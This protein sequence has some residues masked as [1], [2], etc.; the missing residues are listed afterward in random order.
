MESGIAK[1]WSYL[2]LGILALIFGI[3]VLVWPTATVYVLIILFGVY[4][5]V[6][7]VFAVVYSIIRATRGGKF[8]GMLMLGIIGVLVGA[9]VLA[10]PGVSTLAVV[11]V[12]AFWA[13]L[14]GIMMIISAF[15]MTGSA[16][17]RWL[18]GLTGLFA[19]IVGIIF[20]VHPI[21]GVATIILVIG[22]YALVA[23]IFMIVASFPMRSAQKKGTG[24]DTPA[25]A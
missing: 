16:G 1:W 5:L 13:V 24:T 11:W 23:G 14:K 10:R 4:A 20:F 2:L 12:M 19:I 8:F 17:A 9:I 25:A 6:E 21:A 22:I 18:I 7:G 15:E 3:I